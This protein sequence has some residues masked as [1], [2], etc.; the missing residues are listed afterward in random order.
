MVD[1]LTAWLT[2]TRKKNNK[3]TTKIMAN[4]SFLC[5]FL[6]HSSSP[7]SFF[8]GECSKKMRYKQNKTPQVG[9]TMMPIVYFGA[10]TAERRKKLEGWCLV[11]LQPSQLSLSR[12]RSL[13][14]SSLF[15]HP[16]TLRFVLLLDSTEG[17]KAGGG[18]VC[19]HICAI[20]MWGSPLDLVSPI[21]TQTHHLTLELKYV[22]RF[23]FLLFSYFICFCSRHKATVLLY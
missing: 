21:C 19:L 7:L 11:S 15:F 8:F 20:F 5:L 22:A 14:V 2:R 10:A 9:V 13:A 17:R 1:R 12:L 4:L 23:F 16:V 3:K 6:C 18:C